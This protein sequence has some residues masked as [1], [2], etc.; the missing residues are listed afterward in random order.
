MKVKFEKIVDYDG[1]VD[2]YK[3]GS[4]YLM[5]HYY[6]ISNND[7]EWIINSDG[8]QFYFTGEV[9]KLMDAGEIELVNSCKEGKARLIELYK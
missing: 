6:S 1:N 8:K 7:Y 4:H 9:F 2:G 3:L 5:K